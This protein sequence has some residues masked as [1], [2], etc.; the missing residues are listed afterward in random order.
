MSKDEMRMI[1]RNWINYYLNAWD[2]QYGI[3]SQR[4]I[5]THV[6]AAERINYG[7]TLALYYVPDIDKL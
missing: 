2:K 4:S 6:R 7:Y 1:R 5:K 3:P